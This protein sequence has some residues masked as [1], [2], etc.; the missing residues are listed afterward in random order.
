MLSLFISFNTSF[1]LA[2]LLVPIELLSYIF[3]PISL[4]VRLFTNA[5]IYRIN[6]HRQIILLILNFIVREAY[7]HRILL[8]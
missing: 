1:S 8:V 3:K 5:L 6:K 2:L 7:F 4:E